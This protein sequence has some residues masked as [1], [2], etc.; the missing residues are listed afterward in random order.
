MNKCKYIIL[1]IFLLLFLANINVVILSTK[2]ASILF[3]NKVFVSVFPFIILSDIL[4][5]YDYH[6]FINKIFGNIISKLFNIDKNSTIVII[7]SI[8]TSTPN[9]AIYLKDMIDNNLIS[10]STLNKLICFTYY[11]SISFVIGTIGV[12]IF[13]S[14]KIGIFLYTFVF[15]NNILIGLYLRKD[16]TDKINNNYHK[17]K[18]KLFTIIKNS[19]IK[20]INTSFIILG[21]LIIFTIIS[22]IIIKYLPNSV[23]LTSILEITTGINNINK[24]NIDHYLKLYI[25]LFLLCFSGISIIFQG[26]TILNEYNLDIKKILIIKLVFSLFTTLVAACSIA[27]IYSIT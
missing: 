27:S 17:S 18:D 16:S 22:N 14:I 26:T 2:E 13:H 4:I 20:G 25:T 19:I 15:L 10:K 11:P 8:L 9:N 24:L 3:F 12:S 21:N 7:L 6:I 5:Y 1:T 23:I